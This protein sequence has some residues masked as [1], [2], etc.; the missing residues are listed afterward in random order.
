MLKRIV[1]FA[2]VMMVMS[3]GTASAQQCLH[4]ANETEDQAVRRK[5][6]LMATRQVSNIQANRGNSPRLA[7]A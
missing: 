2:A 4:G 5:Q 6:A 3:A 1:T 7:P